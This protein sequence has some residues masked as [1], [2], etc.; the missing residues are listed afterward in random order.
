MD[1]L[2]PLPGQRDGIRV[3]DIGGGL[4]LVGPRLPGVRGQADRVALAVDVPRHVLGRPAQLDQRLLEVPAL[5]GVDQD[6]RVVDAGAEQRGDLA[7]AQHLLQHG[8][9]DRLEHQAV[10]RVVGDLQPAVARHRLGDVD[11]QCVRDGVA[12]VPQERVDHLLRVVPGSP[13]VPQPEESEPV[14]VDVL[15]SALQLGERGV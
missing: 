4:D 5:A 14:N 6:G 8:R 11:E 3:V 12:G 9:V 10:P 1:D 13:G 7:A 2:E 15:G